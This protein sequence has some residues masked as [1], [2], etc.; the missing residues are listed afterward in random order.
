MR[1]LSKSEYLAPSHV[2]LKDATCAAIRAQ[3]SSSFFNSAPLRSPKNYHDALNL[4]PSAATASALPAGCATSAANTYDAVIHGRAVGRADRAV[5][6]DVESADHVSVCVELA[7]DR[8][9]LAGN[10]KQVPYYVDSR[11][12]ILQVEAVLSPYRARAAL[13][14]GTPCRSDW[15]E[16]HRSS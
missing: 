3:A 16:T 7:V 10:P 2:P 8:K 15:V 5:V 9:T 6:V 1:W 13:I 11:V 4:F 14:G 12:G